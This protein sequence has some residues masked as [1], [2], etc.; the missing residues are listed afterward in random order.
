MVCIQQWYNKYLRQKKLITGLQEEGYYQSWDEI[1]IEEY[2]GRRYDARMFY[3][4]TLPLTVLQV[5]VYKIKYNKIKY[6]MLKFPI[7]TKKIKPP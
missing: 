1:K 2:P 5:M 7:N 3:H 4:Q 6:I